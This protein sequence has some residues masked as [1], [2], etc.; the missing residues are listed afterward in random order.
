[1][2]WARHEFTDAFL[3]KSLDW[4]GAKAD[5][6]PSSSTRGELSR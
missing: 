1:M 6:A 5:A 3:D 4:L 2:A